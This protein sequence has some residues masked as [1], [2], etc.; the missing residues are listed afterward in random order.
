MAKGDGSIINR[1]KGIWEVQISFGKNPVTGKYERVSRSVRGTKADARRVRDEIRREH[2][3]GVK[4]DGSKMTFAQLVDDWMQDR[5]EANELAESTLDENKAMSKALADKLGTAKLCDLNPKMCKDALSAI[6][7]DISERLGRPVS[8]SR[9]QKYH[10]T[11]HSILQYAY[12]LDLMAR[13]PMDKL[14]APKR[15]E[16]DRDGISMFDA[17]RLMRCLDRAESEAYDELHGKEQRRAARG[18]ADDMRSKAIGLNGISRLLVVRIALATGMRRGEILG[19]TWQNV[20]LDNAV[21]HV[22]QSL[23]TRTRTLKAPKTKAGRRDIAIDKTTC[24]HLR[25]WKAEQLAIVKT[26]GID[27]DKQA[28]KPVCCSDTCD[29]MDCVALSKWWVAF[30][31]ANGFEGLKLHELRHT[32]AS[33]MLLNGV[34]VETAR[35]R[36]GHANASI[37]L[38]WYAHS[39]ADADRAAA[40]ALGAMFDKTPIAVV[41]RKTA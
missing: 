10:V 14:T 31:N 13:N 25:K 3:A 30:R 28:S 32:V 15:E 21:V 22:V 23:T 9:M 33:Q 34:D 37:T 18:A 41:R 11:L 5:I 12:M 17:Q 16:P 26:L 36:L 40:D 2:D 19:L 27:E 20:D 4:A 39:D 29:F 38:N 24:E 1:G 35:K 7:S 8:N 6:R